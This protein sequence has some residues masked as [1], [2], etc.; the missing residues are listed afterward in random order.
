M[1]VALLF[2]FW[3]CLWRA[4]QA[5]PGSLEVLS[6]EQGL[7]QGY[8]PAI[9]QDDDGFLWFATKNGLNRYDGYQFKVFKNDPYDR[10][11]L[12]ENELQKIFPL[13]D[14]LFVQTLRHSLLMHRATQRFI[15]VF[16]Q[17][18]S[19][20]ILLDVLGIGQNKIYLWV[21][22]IATGQNKVKCFSWPADLAQRM[23]KSLTEPISFKSE[24]ISPPGTVTAVFSLDQKTC[25]M[26]LKNQLVIRDLA[27]GADRFLDLPAG[28]RNK[29]PFEAS[30]FADSLNRLWV[31]E[32]KKMARFDGQNWAFFDLPFLFYTDKKISHDP[33]NG[34]LWMRD[35]EQ[36]RG[37]A[38]YSEPFDPAPRYCLNSL[39]SP[40]AICADRQGNIW[41]GTD[42]LGIR[43][44]TPQAKIFHNYLQGNSIYCR[45]VPN[46][47]GKVF[48][49]DLRRQ[50]LARRLLD[51][52]SGE[53]KGV[54]ELGWPTIFSAAACADGEDGFWLLG[55]YYPTPITG[56]LHVDEERGLLQR[57]PLNLVYEQD[58]FLLRMTGPNE[59]WIL[60]S[61]GITLFDPATQ[62]L[63]TYK[64]NGESQNLRIFAAERDAQGIWWLASENGLLKAE[65]EGPNAFRFSA[66]LNNPNDRNSLPGNFIKSLLIDPDHPGVLWLGT[67]GQ[68]MCRF[69]TEK[70]TFSHWNT[71]NGLPDDVVYGILADDPNA[72]GRRHLWLSTNRGLAR[73]NPQTQQ[74]QYFLKTDGLPDN[75]FNT[76]ASCK[77]PTGELLFGGVNGLTM[78]NP[79]DF[80]TQRPSPAVHLTA[81]SLNGRDIDP[82]TSDVLDRAAPFL[83]RLDLSH[84]QNSLVLSFAAMD[85]T[86]PSRNRFA[87]YLEG[88]EEEWA[89]QGFE[90]TAQYLNLAPGAYTFKVKAANSVGAW[91]EQPATLTIVV[92][93]PWWRSWFAYLV[94]F[95]ATAGAIYWFYRYQLRRRLE[96]TEAERLR[97]LDDFKNRFFT[98]ITH[99]FRTPLTVVLGMVDRLTTEDGRLTDEGPRNSLKLIKR[100]GENLLR[101]INQLLDLAKLESSSLKINYVQGDIVPYLRY[102]AESLQS[103][104]QMQGV[105]LRV[106]AE[107]GAIVM[108]YDPERLL[109]IVHNL[110]SNAIKFTPG[111][112]KVTLFIVRHSSFIILKVED[113][114]AGIPA[115]D[116]PHLFDRFYQAKNLEKARAGGTG[117]GLALTKELVAL[118]GGDISVES[119]VGKGSS[120]TVRLPI[121]QR[122][123]PGVGLASS[124]PDTA[125]TPGVLPGA[126]GPQS[127]PDTTLPQLL[128]VED[129]PDVV[130]YLAQCLKEHYHLDFA[131]NGRAGIE[132]ALETTP[133]LIVS[134]VM[135][136]EKDGFELC[137]ALKND[138]R[139]SHIPIVLL[140][141]KADVENRIAGL[142][143]GADAY[144]AKPFHREEL[145]VT[146]SNLLEL[147]R[148]LQAKWSALLLASTPAAALP[149]SDPEDVF[150][151]KIKTIIEERMSDYGFDVEA[152]SRAV[153]MSSSQL[154]RKVTALTGKS[155]AALIRS[156]RLARARALLQEGGKNVTEV[157][158]EVGFDDPKYFSRVFAEAFGV[159]PS[160]V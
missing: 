64:T 129:N 86:T 124:R 10:P 46:G 77:M 87:Y 53:S 69:D 155:T 56:L 27:S 149:A 55:Q 61:Q 120:F 49:S 73:F 41:I 92:H 144:L 160:K 90:H 3:I 81:L 24:D 123:E 145:L 130:E 66:L 33:K 159:S 142:R 102:I 8:V 151:L 32:R 115:E 72:S 75:E 78:F 147:R 104:A 112:G 26:L 88:A 85:Y 9:C 5:Q 98:N 1:R 122:A 37:L 152:L 15:P 148:K 11:S 51:L 2:I 6:V 60:N 119:E 43:K 105:T 154:L 68:G 79:K 50:R 23:A 4:G 146:L 135:M 116:L 103:L 110:L 89:H 65:P 96:Q 52:A 21:F 31:M 93:P 29:I 114:G 140:T 59:L 13:G 63:L 141:A 118:F 58:Y 100:N 97:G 19:G 156:V 108:D 83:E 158:F 34:L 28:L 22:D 40:I 74:F 38:I 133:D 82:Q 132:K 94:Y 54:E 128:V 113:T 91:N 17:K 20:F 39:E 137:E 127:H 157:A 25:W 30:L 67:D 131:Y 121:A 101:L 111:G 47:K 57:F 125:S 42:A 150:L 18:T 134:D 106:E 7:S 36:V 84:D 153:A 71:Q 109:Q 35:D 80:S 139:T 95:G 62:N 14:Y 126:E 16:D 44:F 99:E 107:A 45:P 136:P 70:G 76:R 117:I 143:H 138:E 12:P 48:L